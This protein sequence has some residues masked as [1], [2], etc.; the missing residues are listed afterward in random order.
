LIKII[1][2]KNNPFLLTNK[3][4][5]LLLCVSHKREAAFLCARGHTYL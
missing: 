3:K 1:F 2:C 5:L 4:M